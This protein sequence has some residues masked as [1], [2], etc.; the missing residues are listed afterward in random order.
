LSMQGYSMDLRARVVK[1]YDRGEGAQVQLAERFGVTSRWIQKLLRQRRETGSIAPQPHGG[2][3][4]AKVRGEKEQVL[5][6]AVAEM[7]DASLAELRDRC[8][9]DG[10]VMCIFRALRRLQITRKKSRSRARNSRTRQSSGSARRGGSG[11]P[12]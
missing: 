2:G 3:R 1:A 5:R 4:K 11:S 8:G 9:V 12:T 6:K 7:P 10:S